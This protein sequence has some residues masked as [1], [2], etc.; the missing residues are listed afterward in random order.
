[1]KTNTLFVFWC[2]VFCLAANNCCVSSDSDRLASALKD[3][4]HSIPLPY[5]PALDATVKSYELKPLPDMFVIYESFLDS[6]LAERNMPL[7]LKY[8]PLAISEMKL[9]YSK[10]DR[11]GVWALPILTGVRYGLCIEGNSDERLAVE[12][13]TR[14]ALDYLADLY[15]EYNDWWYSILAFT[16]GPTTFNHT[17]TRQNDN[18]ELWN[19]H[20]Q[21]LLPDT[22]VIGNFISCVYVYTGKPRPQ[23][24]AQR[25][26]IATVTYVAQPSNPVPSNPVVVNPAPTPQ[27]RPTPPQNNPTVQKYRVK[28]GDTLSKIAHKYHVKVSDLK[29][30]NNLRS[31]FI[32]EGQILI[33]KK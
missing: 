33:I 17:M 7:E 25:P 18:I 1:M 15:Q 3:S 4:E 28:R 32:R 23:T 29:K 16:N 22:K 13:S 10:G 2:L 26:N 27:P 11:S 30:W 31:D 5:N 20:E 14:A 9:D 6:A 19:F 8:L 21:N 12:T 24:Q